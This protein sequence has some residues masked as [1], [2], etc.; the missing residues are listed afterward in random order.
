MTAGPGPCIARPASPRVSR[1]AP[2]PGGV[3]ASRAV[4]W[5]PRSTARHRPQRT[6]TG[7]PRRERQSPRVLFGSGPPAGAHGRR[8]RRSRPG[9]DRLHR[10]SPQQPATPFEAGERPQRRRIGGTDGN[11]GIKLRNFLVVEQRA[12]Q[13]G[14]RRGA[15][16]NQTANEADVQLA[17]VT[18]TSDGQQQA[19]GQTVVKVPAGGFVQ[20]GSPSAARQRHARRL[21]R[22][23]PAGPASSRSTSRRC[24]AAGCAGHVGRSHRHV[25]RHLVPVP[26]LPAADYYANLPAAGDLAPST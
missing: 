19:A 12:G 11:S 18:T 1:R 8:R 23:Q 17:V 14:G 10:D 3:T 5:R 20:L 15:I 26:V 2:A 21:R 9:A 16:S 6:C 13:P 7:G 25:G 24:R 4:G 22:G